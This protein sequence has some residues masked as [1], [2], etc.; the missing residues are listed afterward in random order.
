MKLLRAL[1]ALFALLTSL[2]ALALDIPDIP[3]VEVKAGVDTRAGLTPWVD[4]I[5]T[6]RGST[7]WHG[8]ARVRRLASLVN[9]GLTWDWDMLSIRVS[10][11]ALE[12]GQF[13][14]AGGGALVN[15][16]S[17]LTNP[18]VTV[19]LRPVQM[20][21]LDVDVDLLWAFDMNG[22]PGDFSYTSAFGGLF[23]MWEPV[24]RY[25][26][27]FPLFDIGLG[28]RGGMAWTDGDTAP[29]GYSFEAA[30]VQT[31][32]RAHLVMPI[33]SEGGFFMGLGYFIDPLAGHDADSLL[34]WRADAE[35]TLG[36][37]WFL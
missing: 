21:R 26:G 28:V 16:L 35:W 3:K 18:S 30:R 7:M 25:V 36:L 19:S 14:T 4:F 11:S 23:A 5:S 8:D 17:P 10:D 12:A 29:A 24:A 15:T 9:L 2:P 13:E 6:A 22:S 32:L 31:G 34:L 37:R 33:G 27:A 1:L 20:L